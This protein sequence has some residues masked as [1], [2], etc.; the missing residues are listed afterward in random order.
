MKT[1]VYKDIWD[2]S[3]GNIKSNENLNHTLGI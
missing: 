1:K 2:D 3:I